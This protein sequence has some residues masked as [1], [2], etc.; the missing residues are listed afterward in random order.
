MANASVSLPETG[1]VRLPQV[2]QVFPVSK[3]LWWAGVAEGRYPAPVKLSR[4]CS[5]W[6]VEDIRQLIA[7]RA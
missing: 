7:A 4:R 2:L 3:S 6:R 1:F 5:A